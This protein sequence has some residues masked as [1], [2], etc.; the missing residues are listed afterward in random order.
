MRFLQR[1]EILLILPV[2]FLVAICS[3][4]GLYSFKPVKPVTRVRDVKLFAVV[5]VVGN[6]GPGLIYCKSKFVS[7]YDYEKRVE[8]TLTN[9][10]FDASKRLYSFVDYST[11]CKSASADFIRKA[12]LEGYF[13]EGSPIE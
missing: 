12:V 13:W 11:E 10:A 2:S 9:R 3:V 6:V 4:W 7:S 5:E 1:W 8:I